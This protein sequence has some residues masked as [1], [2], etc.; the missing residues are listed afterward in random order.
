MID[1]ERFWAEI[2]DADDSG[3]RAGVSDE[4][5]RGW[6]SRYATKLPEPLRT[7]L[8]LR[9]GGYVRDTAIEIARLEGIGPVH[10]E[11]WE[12]ADI[13]DEEGT[14]HRLVF[15]FGGDNEAGGTLLMNFNARGAKRPPSVYIDFHGESTE[16]LSGTLSGF[17]EKVLATSAAPSVDWS[18]SEAL[19]IVARDAVD[20]SPMYGGL[21]ASIDQVL[22]RKGKTLI[23][24]TRERSPDGETLTRTKLPLPLESGEA[25][26][27]PFRPAPIS[28]C[29][30]H[31]QPEASD[32]IVEDESKR[33][34]D[35]RW[36]NSRA[37]GVPIYVSFE[38]TDRRRLE[39]LR[40]ELFGAKQAARAQTNEKRAAA[41]EQSLSAL[42]PEQRTTT[43]LQ[44]ALTMKEE[45]D[46]EFAAELG[47]AGDMPSEL[48]QAAEMLQRRME[49]MM[50][51]A[52]QQIS[53]NPP[54]AESLRLLKKMLR[55]T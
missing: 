38:S 45:M 39:S 9:N 28:T 49:Q 7:A 12:F 41:L 30:L 33:T 34:G 42:S 37:R 19:P 55:D 22:A 5:I 36:K 50:Q 48:A 43:L 17:F 46:R 13:D 40:S 44:A 31:L 2:S 14:D 21:A 11:F 1:F 26:I 35:G 15:V 51:Q 52:Q 47:D 18:E 4:Q 25:E 54:D 6:E 23:L 3:E 10:D 53:A 27:G 32:G 24:F 8:R 20:L 29:A 16:R